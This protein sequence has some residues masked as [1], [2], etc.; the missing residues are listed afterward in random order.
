MKQNHPLSLLGLAR[1]AGRL[2]LGA[3]AVE[4]KLR[5]GGALLLIASDASPHTTRRAGQWAGVT[6]T[7]LRVIPY[8]K[9][10]FGRAMGRSECALA[11]VTD[12]GF[13]KKISE[14]LI[15]ES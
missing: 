10:Q 6:E 1:K 3:A 11:L 8:T 7:D 15:D 2:V 12:Q 9:E 4:Q 13:A 14:M 5:Q